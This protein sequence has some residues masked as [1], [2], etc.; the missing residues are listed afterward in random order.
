M[1]ALELIKNQELFFIEDAIESKRIKVLASQFNSLLKEMNN[2]I[3]TFETFNESQKSGDQCNLIIAA[4]SLATLYKDN[5]YLRVE[6]ALTNLANAEKVVMNNY[7]STKTNLLNTL[8]QII[9]ESMK[10]AVVSSFDLFEDEFMK[11]E[12]GHEIIILGKR[13]QNVLE[14]LYK[15]LDQLLI[16]TGAFNSVEE[17]EIDINFEILA[18]NIEL[19]NR[20]NNEIFS[21]KAGKFGKMETVIAKL[22]EVGKKVV[23]FYTC[24]DPLLEIGCNPKGVKDYENELSK[25]YIPLKK[26]IQKEFNIELEDICNVIVNENTFE[27][28]NLDQPI[29]NLTQEIEEV[30]TPSEPTFEEPIIQPLETYETPSIDIEQET[31]SYLNE[32]NSPTD[33]SQDNYHSIMS[34]EQ[35]FT[36]SYSQSNNAPLNTFEDNNYKEVNHINSDTSYLRQ[37]DYSSAP[38]QQYDYAQ[39]EQENE[40]TSDY[41]NQYKDEDNKENEN[42]N[43][44]PNFS[45]K[46]TEDD[47][48]NFSKS[49]SP[50]GQFFDTHNDSN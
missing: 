46:S 35:Q 1:K 4:K 33:S 15:T 50:L 45:N 34:G 47:I 49:E 29:E 23:T 37:D 39:Y 44:D 18:R 42:N 43:F 13:N 7:Y 21:G 11:C 27:E 22:E 6:N 8:R 10:G 9:R 16:I 30:S 12:A 17:Q 5:K 14:S 25:N 19:C 38:S 41:N 40:E 26:T 2:Q 3:N 20:K 31:A 36:N 32:F 24:K 48:H 28:I